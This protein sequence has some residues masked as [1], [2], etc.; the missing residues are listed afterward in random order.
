MT[1]NSKTGITGQSN[2]QTLGSF[3]VV[4]CVSIYS[5]YVSL[6]CRRVVWRA[7]L[8]RSMTRASSRGKRALCARRVQ[9]LTTEDGGGGGRGEKKSNTASFS[10][11]NSNV[12][13]HHPA[14]LLTGPSCDDRICILRWCPAL[15]LNT[16]QR[17]QSVM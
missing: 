8:Q 12:F 4:F 17:Y 1:F 10:R 16:V 11:D 15:E 9:Y 6:G 2:F 3:R 13:S 14:P 5:V 7:R